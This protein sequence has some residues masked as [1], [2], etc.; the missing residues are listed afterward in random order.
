MM[1]Q[2]QTREIITSDHS[3]L[4]GW[5]VLYLA[6]KSFYIAL[7]LPKPIKLYPVDGDLIIQRIVLSM[8]LKI[9]DQGLLLH[10]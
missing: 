8:A 10:E 5:R 3:V 6:D 1:N 2:G 7:L 9:W 4:K